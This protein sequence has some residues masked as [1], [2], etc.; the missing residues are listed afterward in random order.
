MR[1]YGCCDGGAAVPVEL[2]LYFV[3]DGGDLRSGNFQRGFWYSFYGTSFGK[4]R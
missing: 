1:C 3:A 4:E 2:R